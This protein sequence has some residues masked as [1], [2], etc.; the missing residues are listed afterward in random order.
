M[1]LKGYLIYHNKPE[2][3]F[4]LLGGNTWWCSRP[5]FGSSQG[6]LLAGIGHK[7]SNPGWAYARQVRPHCTAP[8]HKYS[9][10]TKQKGHSCFYEF[11]QT[12]AT[13]CHL[14][15]HTFIKTQEVSH[16]GG[17]VHLQSFHSCPQLASTQCP[18]LY[19][20]QPDTSP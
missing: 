6:L 20:H 16:Y 17:G 4:C 8:A 1:E 12:A 15:T 19:L 11:S 5:T 2:L 13:S 18:P 14:H 7:E 10:C 3:N 9:R